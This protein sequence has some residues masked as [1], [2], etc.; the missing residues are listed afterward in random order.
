MT[1]LGLERGPLDPESSARTMRPL[2][3]LHHEIKYQKKRV[4]QI[5]H[6]S[7][8]TIAFNMKEL[9]PNLKAFFLGIYQTEKKRLN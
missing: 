7:L 8:W 3:L 4:T 9:F 1:R 2:R 5:C 6:F